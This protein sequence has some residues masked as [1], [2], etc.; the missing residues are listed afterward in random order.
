MDICPAQPIQDWLDEF[1][2]EHI[3]TKAEITHRWG[4]LVG[5]NNDGDPI[6]EEVRPGVFA[7]GAYN[8]SGNV[9]GTL[10]ARRAVEWALKS[11]EE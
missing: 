8:G 9:L 6:C 1:L 2:R 5:Y 11:L 7:I 4:G 10:Y 3:G